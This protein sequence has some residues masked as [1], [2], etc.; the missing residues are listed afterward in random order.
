MIRSSTLIYAVLAT[1]VITATHAHAQNPTAQQPNAASHQAHH[2]LFTGSDLKW[3]PGPGSLPPGAQ[4]A[5][6]E[7][8]PAQPGP[9]TIRLR[10]PDGYQIAPHWHPGIEHVTV[11]S[12]TFAVG[13]GERA[14]PSGYKELPVGGF[15]VMQPKTTH[16]ARASGD[17]VLQLHGVGPWAVNYVNAA[18]DPRNKKP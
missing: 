4:F 10:L 1:A 14:D 12:G 18:D 8:N 7:G 13:V 15:M 11:L 2:A 16:Y 9:F 5:V 17:T 6:L 3:N